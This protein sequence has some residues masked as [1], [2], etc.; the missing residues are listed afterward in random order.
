M[1]HFAPEFIFQI[2]RSTG[3]EMKFENTCSPAD[4]HGALLGVLIKYP[5]F[6]QVFEKAAS[7][8][9]RFTKEYEAGDM[10]YRELFEQP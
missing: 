10:T 7:D 5:Q 9:R 4:L 1:A 2:K 8:A 3:R 6:I